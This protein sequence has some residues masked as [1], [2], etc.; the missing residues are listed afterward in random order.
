MQQ[1]IAGTINL[2]TTSATL[3]S[4]CHDGMQNV[5]SCCWLTVLLSA[6]PFAPASG[7]DAGART[8]GWPA[9]LQTVSKK[10][11]S[12]VPSVLGRL[13]IAAKV[14]TAVAAAA[15]AAAAVAVAAGTLAATRGSSSTAS[16]GLQRHRVAGL[17]LCGARGGVPRGAASVRGPFSACSNA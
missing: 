16:R 1:L 17:S 8:S 13:A 4:G 15:A 9:V 5:S 2:A 7:A 3:T 14:R 11:S 6:V 10:H 12:A